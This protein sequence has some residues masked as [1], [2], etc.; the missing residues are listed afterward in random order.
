MSE[1]PDDMIQLNKTT[2]GI[3]KKNSEIKEEE[4]T[5]LDLLKKNSGIREEEITILDIL[6][7]NSGIKEDEVPILDILREQSAA[8]LEQTNHPPTRGSLPA[9][10]SALG[11]RGMVTSAQMEERPRKKVSPKT[12]AR[13]QGLPREC[14]NTFSFRKFMEGQVD[15]ALSKLEKP[16]EKNKKKLQKLIM[17]EHERLPGIIQRRKSTSAIFR[18]FEQ[19]RAHRR[20]TVSQ[21]DLTRESRKCSFIKPQEVTDEQQLDISDITV[22]RVTTPRGIVGETAEQDKILPEYG[23][24]IVDPDSVKELKDE[25]KELNK[26]PPASPVKRLKSGAY[27]VP[28]MKN[29]P[30]LN[31]VNTRKDLENRNVEGTETQERP[32]RK[33]KSNAAGYQRMKDS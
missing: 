8:Q 1:I 10:G 20:Q 15:S 26:T 11:F 18:D 12:S 30:Y 16:E 32:S 3:V 25:M 31:A 23:D 13:R 4:T 5:I 22:E 9:I 19:L 2:V 21:E 24:A 27:I 6:K 33:R 7:K 28:M 29:E 17:K 14:R